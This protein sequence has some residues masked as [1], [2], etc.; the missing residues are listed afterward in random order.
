MAA[1]EIKDNVYWV[2][3]VDWALR[4]FHGYSLARKGTTYNAFLVKDQKTALFDTVNSR[5]LDDLLG[6][7][8]QVAAP[9]DI[10]Y[11]FVNHVE[12]DHSGCL[13]TI[14]D[15]VKPEK[16]FCTAMGKAFMISHYHRE[17]WPY[18]IVKTGDSVSLGQKAVHFMEL[19]MLHWPDNMG[20]YI[21]EDRLFIS[22]DAFGHNW[23][24]SER[25]D[26]EVNFS[27][28]RTH[29]ANY[30]ANIIL[31]FSPIVLQALKKIEEME[32]DMDM[33]APSHG[34]IFRTYP[35]RAIEAY[36]EFA[37]Q[38]VKAK[39]VIVYD[40]MWK[41]TRKMAH[42]AAQGLINAGISVRV[43][44]MKACHH[45][46]VMAEVLD[47][48]AVL[49]GSPTHNRGVLPLIAG[50]L[51]YME[52]LRPRGKIGA[53]FGSYGW[54]GEAVEHLTRALEGM[55]IEVIDSFKVRNIPTHDDLAGCVELG[56]R[57]GRTILSRVES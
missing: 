41:S 50:M 45:S 54:G 55:D 49:F 22:S 27:E 16:I 26:D 5:F 43:F 52:G 23:A 2:G 14:L 9:S 57:V 34:L 32:W 46:D 36:R 21:P 8:S 6:S 28:I 48:G 24:T 35:D 7:I 56:E 18:E 3:A 44:D 4:D 29:L 25:F 19:K 33:I 51:R 47:A 53:A 10:D 13:V 15:L 1:I 38:K 17:D 40:T 39:A 42:A 30:Y 11:I 31:P 37:L 12:P 20:C